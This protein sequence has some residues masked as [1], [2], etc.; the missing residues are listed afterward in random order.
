M[1]FPPHPLPS[2]SP[3]LPQPSTHPSTP[4]IPLQ[5]EDF[6][7]TERTRHE[8]VAPLARGFYSPEGA[9]HAPTLPLLNKHS[10]PV[11]W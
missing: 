2:T 1:A 6:E 11:G 8:F 5:V 4:P 10:S 3:T 7:E 9:L